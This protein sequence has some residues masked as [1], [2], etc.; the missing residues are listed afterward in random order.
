MSLACA[1][2][3]NSECFTEDNE[4]KEKE[5]TPFISLSVLLHYAAEQQQ[6]SSNDYF[7]FLSLFP[8]KH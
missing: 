1:A 7:I 3:S 6:N 8:Q 2:H 4:E 5:V